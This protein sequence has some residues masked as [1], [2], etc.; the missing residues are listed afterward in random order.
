MVSNIKKLHS[1]LVLKFYKKKM[2][3]NEVEKLAIWQHFL[4]GGNHRAYPFLIF[5]L[6]SSQI[7]RLHY[8]S[9]FFNAFF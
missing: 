1:V 7:K 6:C 4:I 3:K 9:N 8:N 2:L 5:V